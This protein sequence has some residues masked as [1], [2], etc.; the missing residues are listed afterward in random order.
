MHF[1]IWMLKQGASFTRAMANHWNLQGHQDLHLLQEGSLFCHRCFVVAG[2]AWSLIVVNH[3]NAY[4]GVLPCKYKYDEYG[5]RSCSV[6][7]VSLAT[8]PEYLNWL[9]YFGRVIRSDS[10]I[11]GYTWYLVV[12]VQRLGHLSDMARPWP[13]LLLFESTHKK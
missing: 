2:A 10:Q 6:L 1:D 9:S 7:F 3:V 12:R 4:M 8:W 13:S 11:Q 5:V